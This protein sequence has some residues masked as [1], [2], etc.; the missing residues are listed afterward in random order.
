MQTVQVQASPE[1]NDVVQPIVYDQ[2]G[3]ET[4]KYLPYA[5]PTVDTSDG[6]Y[7]TAALTDQAAFYNPAGS[8]GTQLSNGI[9]RITT[10][11]AV[12]GFEPS[13]LNRPLEQGAPGD[14]WQLTG[15]TGLSATPGHTV[16]MDYQLNAA[17]EVQLWLLNSNGATAAS[18]YA[19][20]TLYKIITKDENWTSGKTGITEEFND[21]QDHMV[22]KRVWKDENH[23]LS[24]YYVYDDYHNLAYVI[25]SAVTVSS[26]TEVSTDT[27]FNR[28]IYAYHY[29]NRNRVAEKKIPG[30]G[31]EY[32]AYNNID[33]PVATQ[34]AIQ[35]PGNKWTFSKYD[36][37]GRVIMTGELID[38]RTHQQITDAIASQTVN[39]ETPNNTYTDGYTTSNSFPTTWNLLY[40]VNYYDDYTFPGGTTYASTATGITNNAIGLLTGTKTRVLNTGAMLLTENYYDSEGRLRESIIQNNIGGSDR[41]VN[42]Y[43][44]IGQLTQ[45]VRTHNSSSQTNLTVTNQYTYDQVGR[46]LQSWSGIGGNDLTQ[47]NNLQYNEIGQLHKKNIG[48]AD[49]PSLPADV[50]LGAADAITTGTLNVSATN[51]IIL[52]TG[53]SVGEGATAIFEVK[54]G[55]LQTIT[56]AYNERG[57]LSSAN[58]N[59]NLF[60][61]QLQYNGGTTP[62][63]NGNISQMNYTGTNSG[64]KTFNYTYDALNRLTNASST[65]SALDEGITYDAMGNITALTRSGV[66]SAALAYAYTGNQLNSVTNSGSA[67]RTYAYDGN[68]NATSDGGS[69]TILYN[70]L[71]L[72]DT[73]TQSGSTIATYTYDATGNKLKNTG[74]DGTWDY[75][76]GI[77]YHNGALDFITTEDGRIVPNG[78]GYTYQYNLQDHLGNNRV[79]FY[80]NSGTATLLQEDEY[81]SFGLRKSLYDNASN[82]RYLYNGKEIQTDLANQYDYGARFYDPVIA[83][84]TVIDPLAEISR[85]WSPYNYVYSNPI[86]NVDPDGMWS[87]GADGYSSDSPEE[88]QA[89]FIQLQQQSRQKDQ[90]SKPKPKGSGGNSNNSGQ[91]AVAARSSIPEK[92]TPTLSHRYSSEELAQQAAASEFG[93]KVTTAAI[94]DNL[95]KCSTCIVPNATPFHSKGDGIN[96]FYPENFLLGLAIPEA[97]G[98]YLSAGAFTT[99]EGF[100]FGSIGFKAPID[101]NVGL[102]ASENTIT[103]GAFKWSTMAPDSFGN[104][105]WF[106]R[107]ML[108]ISEDFQ[109]QLGT[110]SSQVIPKGTYIKVGL[111]GPQ[112][113]TSIGTW[114]QIYAPG[115]VSFLK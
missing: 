79:S 88:A 3:R 78:T 103:N 6:R 55:A 33:Q 84:W 43:N 25:P 31:W 94:R 7:R 51:S 56:Y 48:G 93:D 73:L 67:F 70:Y 26:F 12:T 54:T 95:T 97:A 64:S 57:W 85:R 86:R 2:Y 34:D 38:S 106:G 100:L 32:T 30:K 115:K 20:N 41:I 28:Y 87:E 62:Q 45:S 108:Q 98:G 4:V 50:T 9:A 5:L 59:S 105:Q 39:W 21:M 58:S 75:D 40:T 81:Y 10:P 13:P 114:L 35:R 104:S 14:A 15:T 76:N 52:D 11:Y 72:P 46:K 80:G 49:D 53:M 22:L 102:Y 29:D 16:K 91:R 47:L 96:G 109:P 60:N 66:S 23:S 17:N 113:G 65:G 1:G 63:Y 92:P 82:N 44:F 42:D 101:L 27:A 99:E 112:P 36:G 83:R 61:E 8:S 107:N 89:L 77:V 69:K 24:T 37:Q 90:Q 18:A 68:G 74:T 71:N 19:A 111:V 110:W